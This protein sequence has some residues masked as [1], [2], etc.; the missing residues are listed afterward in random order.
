MPATTF[1]ANSLLEHQVGKTAY[2]MPTT[3]LALSSTT[4]TVGGTNVTEPTG[5][6]YARVATAGVWGTAAAGAITNTG[7][8]TFTAASADW[9]SGANLT[10]GVLYDA[11]TAGNCLGFGVLTVAKN[12]L[13]GDTASVAAGGVTI[14]LS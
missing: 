4:P 3:Y 8:I 2:T 14:T 10:Y 1:L 5:G 7:A 9:L 13:A 11:A 6:A 12:I